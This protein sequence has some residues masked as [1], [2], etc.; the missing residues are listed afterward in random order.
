MTAPNIQ[1]PS[2]TNPEQ[3]PNQ[4]TA[5]LKA[6]VVK[7]QEALERMTT[8][9][10]ALQ[11][12]MNENLTKLTAPKPP[13][14]KEDDLSNLWK[15][16]DQD[17]RQVVEKTFEIKAAPLKD[18]VKK[19]I[20]DEWSRERRTEAFT[21]QATKE[22]PQLLKEG[23]PL[24]NEYLKV[25]DEKVRNDPEFENSP[26]AVYD[27]AEIAYARLVRTGQIIPSEFTDEVRRLVSVGDSA[28]MSIGSRPPSK[29]EEMND[30]Q[31]FW[32]QRLK[33]TPDKYLKHVRR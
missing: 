2:T 17:N 22:F 16:F 8:Q 1:Q 4:E 25:Y 7:Q 27:A 24:R 12:T 33:V 14:K 29:P 30:S 19:E 28:L 5:E 3:K 21:H 31:K 32:A 6:L 13:E 15:D 18:A 23:H 26:S 11:N 10:S 20:R 9:F